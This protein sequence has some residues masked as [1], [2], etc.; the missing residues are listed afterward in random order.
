[1]EK[2]HLQNSKIMTPIIWYPIKKA[3]NI[4]KLRSNEK[5]IMDFKK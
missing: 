3:L 2:A 4:K 5:K 1:M